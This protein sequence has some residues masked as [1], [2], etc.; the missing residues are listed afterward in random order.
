[1]RTALRA[2]K[3]ATGYDLTRLFVG[4]EGTLGVITEVTVRLFGIPSAICLGNPIGRTPPTGRARRGGVMRAIKAAI[5]PDKIM[6]PGKI[7]RMQA[8]RFI[9]KRGF[10][11]QPWV[12]TPGTATRNGLP[13]SK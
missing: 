9:S 6:N 12:S 1:M 11:T 4:S 13:T 5:D 10:R 3:S 8:S 2:R 7:F